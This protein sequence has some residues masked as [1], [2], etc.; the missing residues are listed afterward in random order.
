V[1]TI[2]PIVI[3]L[4]GAPTTLS[5]LSFGT[6]QVKP[7]V[8][9]IGT[10]DANLSFKWEMAMADKMNA[11]RLLSEKM[12]LDA[13]VPV[14]PNSTPYVLTLTVTDGDTGLQAFQRFELYITASLGKGLIVADTDDGIS[15]D[16]NLV[17]AKEFV[18]GSYSPFNEKDTKVMYDVFSSLNGAPL[19]GMVKGMISDYHA[20][21]P[22][23]P[24]TLTVITDNHIYRMDP[25]DYLLLRKDSEMFYSFEEAELQ[26]AFI[27][28]TDAPL[29]DVLITNGQV[30][31]RI[32]QWNEGI[33]FRSN[34]ETADRSPY[35]ATMGTSYM[36]GRYRTAWCCYDEMN[37]RFLHC[38]SSFEPSGLE[39]MTAPVRSGDFDLNNLGEDFKALYMGAAQPVTITYTAIDWWSGEEYTM[40][41]EPHSLFAAME[42]RTSGKRYLFTFMPGSTGAL[43]QYFPM[44]K[45]DLSQ[46]AGFAN[47][48]AWECTPAENVFYYATED[49]VYS[50]T[51]STG[52]PVINE[53]FTPEHGEKITAMML[54]RL[55]DQGMIYM[56]NTPGSNEDRSLNASGNRMM[57]IATFNESTGEGKLTCIPIMNL[58]SGTLEPDKNFHVVFDGF[59]RIVSMGHQPC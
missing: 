52:T 25:Y 50:M 46:A 12:E 13:V 54:W 39:A 38:G 27:G 23:Q 37:R 15:S 5:V 36:T 30:Y 22:D 4:S 14:L 43:N 42:S 17:M 34:M 55:T 11:T 44:K 1:K 58:G 41:E 16:L 3:D 59:G 24:R 20:S 40:T 29:Y 26:P 18:Q 56:K 47:S 21:S 33:I 35:Y 53:R 7:V 9:K 49:R 10:P 48:I 31:S 45:Y 6:V 2:N 57:V 51:L 19:E 8:Y 32:A 28:V